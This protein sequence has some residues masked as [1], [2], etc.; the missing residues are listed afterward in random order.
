[1]AQLSTNL[2]YE[3]MITR[4]ASQLNPILANIL[5][6]GIPLLGI[7]LIAATPR[8]LNHYLGRTQKGWVISDIT[9]SATVFRSQPFNDKTITLTSSADTVIDL[10]IY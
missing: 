5:I 6:Q 9:T 4:W 8:T 2:T 3:Q 10:W 1:M 7:T